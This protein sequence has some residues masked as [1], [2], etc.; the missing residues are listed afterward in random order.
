MLGGDPF[1]VVDAREMGLVNQITSLEKL[2]AT[3]QEQVN[4]IASKPAKAVMATKRLL[5]SPVKT[6]VINAIETES[7]LFLELLN[8]TESKAI[9]QA[10]LNR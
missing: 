5:K 3:A 8:E 4:K 7:R 10:F 6:Q 2:M 9:M 1:S